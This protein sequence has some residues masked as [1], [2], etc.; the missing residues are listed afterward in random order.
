M[1]IEYNNQKFDID[2]DKARELGLIKLVKR[3]IKPSDIPN[4]SIFRYVCQG[5]IRNYV[6]LN[7]I[8]TGPGQC[9]RTDI[10][11]NT[12]DYGKLRYFNENYQFCASEYLE[13][14]N[15]NTKQWIK[16]I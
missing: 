2:F 5:A 13:Y 1:I 16:E 9:I 14:Y 8:N 4:G 10:D 3:L 11:C 6:M 12:D 7:N 15:P